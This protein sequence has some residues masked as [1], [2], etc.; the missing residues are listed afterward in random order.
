MSPDVHSAPA[1]GRPRKRI[2]LVCGTTAVLVI[3]LVATI[4]STS[5]RRWTD[6]LK[7]HDVRLARAMAHAAP[8]P[9]VAGGTEAGEAHEFYARA[10]AGCPANLSTAKEEALQ[11][12]LYPKPGQSATAEQASVARSLAENFAPQFE[13]LRTAAS[14]R[15]TRI[16]V[17]WRAGSGGLWRTPGMVM[18]K[19][20]R[21]ACRYFCLAIHFE[22][23]SGDLHR[24]LAD[25]AAGWQAGLDLCCAPGHQRYLLGIATLTGVSKEAWL[26]AADPRLTASDAQELRDLALRVEAA[27]PSLEDTLESEMALQ[28]E[29][30]RRYVAGELSNEQIDLAEISWKQTRKFGFSM[31]NAIL[32][33]M[34]RQGRIVEE[35]RK[36]E[37]LDAVTAE[38]RLDALSR[39][40]DAENF[41][42]SAWSSSY[43]TLDQN[44]RRTHARF[45][46]IAALCEER[47]TGKPPEAI[48]P[49][50]LKP[51]RRRE[52]DG[53]VTWWSVDIDG[54]D[55]GQGGF[56]SDGGEDL[57]D[58][59]LEWKR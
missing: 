56:W 28:G 26:I 44:L 58:I 14:Q 25:V 8:P 3:A 59:V 41:V 54:D 30:F 1:P 46:L 15:T 27:L 42:A 6:F 2:L 24:A 57:K 20:L 16:Q 43:S 50:D 35:A 45:R 38:E 51:L 22:R 4:V 40:G 36:S 52:E 53:K 5:H 18:E 10:G 32:D 31:T 34:E 33:W 17:D 39:A 29:T 23:E 9:R 55:G 47:A 19:G 21:T 11:A 13:L 12:V 7:Q 37:S 48:D 49:F